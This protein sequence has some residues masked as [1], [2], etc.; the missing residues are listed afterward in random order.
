MVN[1]EKPA[2]RTRRTAAPLAS[3][4][5]SPLLLTGAAIFLTCSAFLLYTLVIEEEHHVID[6][7]RTLIEEITI[8]G[9]P[10]IIGLALAAI[11]VN[12][13]RKS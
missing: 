11:A 3:L 9:L 4:V 6:E 8:I 1:S 7:V 2:A 12:R 13:R 10:A 5:P